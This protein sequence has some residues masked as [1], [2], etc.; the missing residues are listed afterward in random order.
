MERE[1]NGLEAVAFGSTD[2][3]Q[4]R[5]FK[6]FRFSRGNVSNLVRMILAV[7]CLLGITSGKAMAASGATP[8]NDIQD[9]RNWNETR[10]EKHAVL[11]RD[12]YIGSS[13]TLKNEA[14]SWAK[15]LD[16]NHNSII[17]K[18]GGA[19]IIN[20]ADFLLTGKT[21]MIRVE[22]GGILKL[23][24]GTL[25]GDEDQ[26]VIRIKGNK[27][28]EPGRNFNLTGRILRIDSEESESSGTNTRP[29]ISSVAKDGLTYVCAV[30]TPVSSITLP[31]SVSIDYRTTEGK[32]EKMDLPIK[33][34]PSELSTR[35]P[36]V[37]R[38]KGT[39]TDDTLKHYNLTNPEGLGAVLLLSVMK[40]EDAGTLNVTMINQ[41]SAGN[42]V[43]RLEFPMLASDVTALYLYS[44]KDGQHFQKESWIR[45][46]TG[47]GLVSNENFLPKCRGKVNPP[48]QYLEYRCR[49]DGPFWLQIEVVGSPFAGR[50]NAV[51]CDALEDR[52]PGKMKVYGNN[53][54]QNSSQST[55]AASK[56]PVQAGIFGNSFN[57]EKTVR[58]DAGDSGS[59][60]QIG[61]AAPGGGQTEE[62]SDRGSA[63]RESAG[64]DG[65]GVFGGERT[66]DG[67]GNS[68]LTGESAAITGAA[69]DDSGQEAWIPDRTKAAGSR[70]SSGAERQ[71]IRGIAAVAGLLLIAAFL[72]V[73][74]R[75]KEKH[76]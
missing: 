53:S 61:G 30:G 70:T 55:A 21:N 65:A 34:D 4:A 18:P 49:P 24:N 5:G 35:A 60:A 72:V 58:P 42:T 15:E 26:A 7:I 68:D 29:R 76:K 41:D 45:E 23:E 14:L 69:G 52:E 12:L 8:I 25:R 56:A 64:A 43:I 37:F 74:K 50:S 36:G 13:V 3:G 73:W 67:S 16:V 1:I 28:W 71:V 51:A 38:I 19:L 66:P 40:P 17:I 75:R 59:R 2:S 57:E 46:E 22:S 44:S 32:T 11:K 31:P 33:W 9:L 10:G 20:N 54:S 62:L 63:G 27:G 48:W 47:G 6:A 39:F